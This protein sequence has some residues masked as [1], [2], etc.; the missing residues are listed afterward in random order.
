MSRRIAREFGGRSEN[1]GRPLAHILVTGAAGFIGRALCRDLVGS[2]HAVTGVTRGTTAPIAGVRV[3]AVGDIGPETDWTSALAGVDSV[4]H[5]A[6]SAHRPQRE[7]AARR[8]AD[9][10]AALARACAQAGVRRLVQVSSI[11]AMGAETAPGRSLSANDRPAP[12]DVYGRSK[13]AIET[14]V[15]VAAAQSGF[16]LAIIRPPLVYGPGVKGN[17]RALIRLVSSGLPL[18]FAAVDNR[19]SL[20]GRD[21]LTSLLE[22]AATHPVAAGHVWLARDTDLST[23][24]L[25]RALAR[26]LAIRPRLWALPPAL[27][28]ALR[29]LPPLTAGVSRLTTSLTVDDSATRQLLGWKPEVAPAEGLARTAASIARRR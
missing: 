4:I 10:A 7:A 5:L 3:L 11:R 12:R 6:G 25:I 29:A 27:L 14:A 1:G 20:I 15:T 26:G 18:P 28:A 19:R 23:P 16:E 9:A 24:E 8:E 17:L 21:N 22:L 13:L 2:G